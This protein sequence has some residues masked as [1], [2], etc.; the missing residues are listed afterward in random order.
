MSSPASDIAPAIRA[1]SSGRS[2]ATTVTLWV[3]G[4]GP[5]PTA[6]LRLGRAGRALQLGDEVGVAGDLGGLRGWRGSAA[7]PARRTRARRRARRPSLESVAART[8]SP[9]VR[10]ARAVDVVGERGV[11]PRRRACRRATRS[12]AL[13]VAGPVASESAA[14]SRCSGASSSRRPMRAAAERIA[15]SS[16]RS[17]RVGGLGER[18]V[19][20]DE[21]GDVVGRGRRR[22][23]GGARE[24]RLARRRARRVR[25]P[26]VPCRRRAR[27]RR[28]AATRGSLDR[29]ARASERGLGRH[30]HDEGGR[31]QRVRADRELVAE[32]G[33][34][35]RHQLAEAGERAASRRPACAASSSA[36]ARSRQRRAARR[37]RRAAERVVG[38]R[39]LALRCARR[40]RA[41][42]SAV[43][44]SASWT[45][46]ASRPP[47]ACRR[48]RASS[49]AESLREPARSAR[50]RSSRRRGRPS[51]VPRR[52]QGPAATSADG[53]WATRPDDDRGGPHEL[54]VV[55]P[56]AGVLLEVG[57]EQVRRAGSRSVSRARAS[58][59]RERLLRVCGARR[60]H[61][62]GPRRRRRRAARPVSAAVQRHEVLA[63]RAQLLRAASG[64]G[65]RPSAP[66]P[67][68]G[69]APPRRTA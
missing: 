65:V 22:D 64:P 15:S 28:P 38:L 10:D 21:V 58:S 51:R 16:S 36:G 3:S 39:R 53:S 40:T 60:E 23:R 17:T 34:A 2:T 42:T 62:L 19:E 11:E 41:S 59:R 31:A 12:T 7:V 32:A 66:R 57:F 26:A 55:A 33:A 56:T 24:P 44:A 20:A 1:S 25:C 9:R 6:T 46:A 49:G 63:H 52:W 47:A 30:R 35:Q 45:S 69:R 13:H 50:R 43:S 14:V 8:A 48:R 5:A 18:E 27:A 67:T 54:V 37:A 61:A 29:G 68:A 4:V